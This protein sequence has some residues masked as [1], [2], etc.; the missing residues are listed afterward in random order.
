[1]EVTD[2]GPIKFFLGI[3]ISRNR[4]EKSITLSQK[5]YT[6]KLL[7]KFASNVKKTSNPCQMG[8]RLEPNPDK[9]TPEDIHQYQQQIGSLMYLMTA[10][11]PDLAY[12]V[13]LL[14]RFMSNPSL[15]HQKALHRIWEYVTY[16]IDFKLTYKSNPNSDTLSGY[17][18]SDW[19]GDIHTRKS[20]TGYI[21]LFRNSPISWNSR[22]QKTVA[23]SSCEAEYMALKEAIKEQIYLKSL[24]GQI[25]ILKEQFENKLYTDSQSAIELA[26]N[27]IYHNRTKHIDIQYHFVRQA[28]VSRLTNLVY[29]PTERQ[30]ADG[31]TKPI[32]N[33]KWLKFVQ[34][35]GITL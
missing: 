34:E 3:E 1:M 10:T 5:G 31:L 32:D 8:Y 24:F 14:A 26:K 6:Q 2:L 22:L 15:I 4:K 33:N 19:G 18:D 30:L 25:P 13:G 7:D 21:F 17:C 23:L 35:L 20:T 9:A 27:P 11:R 28:Y 29:T 12:P 16:S